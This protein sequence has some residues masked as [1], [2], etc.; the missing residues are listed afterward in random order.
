MNV[1]Y[2]ESG[3]FKSGT[4]LADNDS[5]LQV[6]AP[7]G[8]RSKIKATAVLL[9]FDQPPP[10]ELMREAEVYAAGVDTEFLWECS[11]DAEFEF[12][13]L[14]REYCGRLP[15]AT[16]SAGILFK[17]HGAPMYFYRKG[18]GRYRAAPAET[19]KAALASQEKKR[20]AQLQVDEWAKELQDGSV[21][22]A[23]RTVLPSLLYKPDRNTPEAKA[24]EKAC[25]SAGLSVPRLLERAGALPSSHAYH[26]N[27]FLFEHFP[28]GT[29]FPAI[30]E[31]HAPAELPLARVRAFSLDDVAT[32]EIDDALSVTQIE[33]GRLRIGIH[34]AAPA[35]G[36]EPGSP[37]DAIARARL[38]TVYMPGDKITMLPDSVVERFSLAEGAD[39]PAV[40]LYV[41]VRESDWGVENMH[42]V[43]E[44][45]PVVSNLRHQQLTGVDPAFLAGNVPA[46][47]FVPELHKLWGFAVALE[48]A[49][50]KPS[51]GQ[52]RADYNFY[53]ERDGDGERIAIVERPRGTPLDKLVAELMILANS[54]W[55]RMLDENGIAAIYRSQA[56]GKVRMGT[57]AA[58]HQGLGIDHYAWSTSPLRRYVDLV[59]QWQLAALLLGEA[60]PFQQGEALQAAV[61]D[62][63]T[64]YSAYADFQWRME[65]YWCLRW[66]L[67]EGISVAAAEVLRDNLLRFERLPL[68]VRVAGLPQM[69]PGTRVELQIDNIDLLEVE[70]RCSYRPAIT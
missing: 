60:P 34:I 15:S 39:H 6:E 69:A 35:L 55:G 42:T 20:R 29:D 57:T 46:G 64:T 40:S 23:L 7:H 70:L 4:V 68:V 9:R 13:S 43:L 63:E 50:G 25:E 41:D 54:T 17:L 5:S 59:N 28:R 16:E 48:A 67:Q 11:G 45:V 37:P 36:F 2:E 14:A 52:D 21:P 49:R 33:P 62:F 32:T 51:V 3:S 27:R 8:K 22:E 44:R 18:K 30:G 66:L 65:R 31:I 58:P 12:D 10:A 26:L 24:L 61:H 56:G 47:D 19:L 53:V 1:L 38:S